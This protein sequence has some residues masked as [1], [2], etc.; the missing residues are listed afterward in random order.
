MTINIITDKLTNFD[1]LSF[2]IF[3]PLSSKHVLIKWLINDLDQSDV[4]K[5]F[6]QKSLE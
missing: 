6:R 5:S 3:H 4:L 1:Y 2:L